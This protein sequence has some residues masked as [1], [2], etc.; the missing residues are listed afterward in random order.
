MKRF[1]QQSFIRFYRRHKIIVNL[2]T[3]I[4]TRAKAK[5]AKLSKEQREEMLEQSRKEGREDFLRKIANTSGINTA[6]S[7]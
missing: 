3:D 2:K 1:P 4:R 6:N 7:M 5:Q